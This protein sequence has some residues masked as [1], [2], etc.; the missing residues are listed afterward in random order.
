MQHLKG[1]SHLSARIKK[2]CERGYLMKFK[3][4]G[5]RKI[6]IVPPEHWD[7]TKADEFLFLVKQPA[8]RGKRYDPEIM[9][10]ISNALN[11]GLQTAY[12]VARKAK[13]HPRVAKK[14][15]D[16]MAENDIIFK[17]EKRGR[18][19]YTLYSYLHRV[20]KVI[21]GLYSTYLT[22]P[23]WFAENLKHVEVEMQSE[24]VII[25]RKLQ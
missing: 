15:L 12:A 14:Y 17:I 25:I 24:D 1:S 13:V 7:I 10:R 18:T 19:Y 6:Y 11:E 5:G 2:L 23:K 20:Q 9:A 21:E 22:L 8:K 3:A 16:Y 4:P